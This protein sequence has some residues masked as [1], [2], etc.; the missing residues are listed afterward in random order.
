MKRGAQCLVAAAAAGLLVASIGTA[1]ADED[2]GG[3]HARHAEDLVDLWRA[4][5]TNT[6]ACSERPGPPLP[7]QVDMLT[8]HGDGTITS[9]FGT[10]NFGAF[11]D[12]NPNAITIPT[13]AVGSLGTWSWTGHHRVHIRTVRFIF[14]PTDP[15]PTVGTPANLLNTQALVGYIVANF[16]GKLVGPD[17]VTGTV[18]VR[19]STLDGKTLLRCYTGD[20]TLTRNG[21]PVPSP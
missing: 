11:D 15:P 19:V 21:F 5:T 3:E 8:V 13:N 6:V 18:D 10:H 17:T 20:A 2:G 4:E 16:S 9:L 1:F 7:N 14:V 12:R